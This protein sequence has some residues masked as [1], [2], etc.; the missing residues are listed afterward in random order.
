MGSR[1]TRIARRQNSMRSTLSNLRVVLAM[2]LGLATTGVAGPVRAQSSDAGPAP[3]GEAHTSAATDPNAEG[4][5][6]AAPN[7]GFPKALSPQQRLPENLQGWLRERNRRH[8]AIAERPL[9]PPPNLA[10]QAAAAASEQQ[11]V[12]GYKRRLR[13]FDEHGVTV[14]SNR[15]AAEP[16]PEPAPKP[17]AA[18]AAIAVAASVPAPRAEDEPEPEE[19]PRTTETHSLRAKQTAKAPLPDQG[20]RWPTFAVPIAAIGLALIWFRRRRQTHQ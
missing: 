18:T 9:T 3:D 20:L 1:I 11:A 15:R 2:L 7:N 5:A 16:A 6:Q 13:S 8:P 17:V 4:A 19:A 10:P 14:L 12:E